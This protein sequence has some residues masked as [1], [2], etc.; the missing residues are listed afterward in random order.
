MGE[1]DMKLIHALFHLFDVNEELYMKTYYLL[2]LF[3][4]LDIDF[5]IGVKLLI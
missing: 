1:K 3:W 5:D 2:C 4:N